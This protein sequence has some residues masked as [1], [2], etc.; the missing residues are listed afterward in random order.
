LT[1][2]STGKRIPNRRQFNVTSK[3][4]ILSPSISPAAR[5]QV[6]PVEASWLT[7]NV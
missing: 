1:G 7:T 6:A 2:K 3:A 4:N 5:Q